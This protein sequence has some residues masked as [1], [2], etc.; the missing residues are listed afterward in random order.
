[1]STSTSSAQSID[2]VRASVQWIDAVRA[3]VQRREGTSPISKDGGSQNIDPTVP[4]G[5]VLVSDIAPPA[6][7]PATT[8]FSSADQQ[9]A[10]VRER[11]VVMGHWQGYVTEVSHTRFR[12]TIT[13]Q[14]FGRPDEE[15]DFSLKEVPRGDRPL[16][17]PGAV[18]YLTVGYQE[19]LGGAQDNVARIR[20]QRLPALTE[21]E[22]REDRGW[23]KEVSELLSHGS[24]ESATSR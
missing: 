6:P 22:I 12:A 19:K 13:D 23:A 10:S 20:V 17:A 8:Q 24:P 18:F 14:R 15:A 7:A 2:A 4:T 5:L 21:E 3:S 1:V 9:S 11:F 16:I